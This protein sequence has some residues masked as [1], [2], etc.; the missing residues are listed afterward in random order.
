MV[1]AT[2]IIRHPQ[3]LHSRPAA[4]FYRTARGYKSRVTIRNLSRP[5]S[6]EVPVSLYNL[7]QIG[8][9]QGH[10]LLVRADGEDEGDVIRALTALVEHG[11]REG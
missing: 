2:L 10:Q 1:E 7:L 9:A 3:G 5:N 4:D 8:V 11:E 6:A